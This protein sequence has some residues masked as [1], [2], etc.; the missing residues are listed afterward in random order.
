M[1]FALSIMIVLTVAWAA[2]TTTGIVLL[3][4]GLRGRRGDYLPRCGQCKYVIKGGF[5]PTRC[6]E[7][8]V[9]LARVG[10]ICRGR[11]RVYEAPLVFGVLLTVIGVSAVV[12]AT[13]RIHPIAL[14]PLAAPQLGGQPAGTKPPANATT[15]INRNP[16]S[17]W[18]HRFPQ[19]VMD[20]SDDGPAVQNG[21]F[22]HLRLASAPPQYSAEQNSMSLHELAD[23]PPLPTADKR[24]AREPL[25]HEAG[26]DA[27]VQT[28]FTG[29][30]LLLDVAQPGWSRDQTDVFSVE[31][32]PLDF[33]LEPLLNNIFRSGRETMHP[34][35]T[36]ITATWSADAKREKKPLDTRMSSNAVRAARIGRA[37][38]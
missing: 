3:L 30:V 26:D 36:G 38:R 31:I 5:D 37:R 25:R 29:S 1:N 11:R 8:G 28:A 2:V 35:P 27:D 12:F 21:L 13:T 22:D 32:T 7:C 10:M 20:N 19:Q 4:L 14:A 16:P 9:E 34:A 18:E 24:G 33:D 15:T 23:A 17:P 6:S